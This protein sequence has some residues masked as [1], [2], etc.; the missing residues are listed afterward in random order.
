MET[1]KTYWYK[2]SRGIG[3]ITTSEDSERP[4]V[5]G[6]LLCLIHGHCNKTQVRGEKGKAAREIQV[7]ITG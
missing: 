7:T 5:F 3:Y 2:K 6:E 4:N 1:E